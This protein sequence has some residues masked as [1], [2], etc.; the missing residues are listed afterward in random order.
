MELV[1]FLV[2]VP[3]AVVGL[4]AFALH[5]LFDSV[6]VRARSII[7]ATAL[8]VVCAPT[9]VVA[10]HGAGPAPFLIALMATEPKYVTE[11]LKIAAFTA[12]PTWLLVLMV[13]RRIVRK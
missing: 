12:P 13:Y 1:I 8:T 2:V 9:I 7:I 5:T 3:V 4:A 11:V 6:G 10:G